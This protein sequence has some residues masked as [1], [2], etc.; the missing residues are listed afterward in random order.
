MAVICNGIGVRAYA[1]CLD[2][3]EC[4]RIAIDMPIGKERLAKDVRQMTAG[5]ERMKCDVLHQCDALA[6]A[7]GGARI[8]SPLAA[9]AIGHNCGTL[10]RA[11]VVGVS[12]VV[13]GVAVAGLDE[14]RMRAAEAQ[15][16]GVIKGV[17]AGDSRAVAE[18]MHY[19][20][21]YTP[22]E[23]K[24]DLTDVENGIRFLL[25]RFGRVSDVKR[26]EGHV[27]FFEVGGGGGDMGYWKSLSPMETVDVI[28]SAKFS[29]LGRGVIK[30]R[31]F[32]HGDGSAPGIFAVGFGLP[33]GRSDART[34]IASAMRDMMSVRGEAVPPDFESRFEK[35]APEEYQGSPGDK[36]RGKRAP[37]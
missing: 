2:G 32:W 24:S 18:L 13:A 35:M 16:G 4:L 37:Y 33:V 17:V 15:A 9:M 28:Y 31:I 22:E 14:T 8:S 20:P 26:E 1:V 12:L 25:E 23:R 11:V 34:Q 6:R 21:S 5:F 36:S 27:S 19:P 3:D 30:I 10:A 7:R 29:K